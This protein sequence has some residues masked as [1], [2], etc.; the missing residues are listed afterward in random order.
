MKLQ[1]KPFR[2]SL[3]QFCDESSPNESN[4]YQRIILLKNLN[5]SELLVTIINNP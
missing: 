4:K 3:H 5:L 1:K 2:Y